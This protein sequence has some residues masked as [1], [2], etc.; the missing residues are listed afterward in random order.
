MHNIWHNIFLL[1][2]NRIHL[3]QDV[4]TDTPHPEIRDTPQV[5]EDDETKISACKVT[6]KE[7]VNT[8]EAF[9]NK[10]CT[11]KTTDISEEEKGSSEKDIQGADSLSDET[12]EEIDE[13]IDVSTNVLMTS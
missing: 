9:E 3:A 5:A 13:V 4:V 11:E 6:E 12:K 8:V 10:E 7:V 2:L 1:K